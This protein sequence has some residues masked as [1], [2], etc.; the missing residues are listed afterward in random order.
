MR[1]HNVY[2]LDWVLRLAQNVLGLDK[3]HCINGESG[4][5]FALPRVLY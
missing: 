4:E 5:Q 1:L 3:T 2:S